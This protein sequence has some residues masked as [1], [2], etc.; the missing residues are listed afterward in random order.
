MAFGAPVGESDEN[1]EGTAGWEGREGRG[2]APGSAPE[3]DAEPRPRRASDD[4]GRGGR[5]V[6]QVDGSEG[7]RTREPAHCAARC[8][9]HVR[10]TPETHAGER[11]GGGSSRL[12]AAGP[13]VFGGPLQRAPCA[14][15]LGPGVRRG[16]GPGRRR[17]GPARASLCVQR[18][19]PGV[20]PSPS[21]APGAPPPLTSMCPN[22]CTKG[23]TSSSFSVAR[24]RISLIS[25]G[26]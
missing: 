24:R 13:G 5:Q 1:P 17:A 22:V 4:P 10:V 2:R 12:D 25:E 20:A 14:R 11:A 6:W 3:P 15:H 26:L 18:F 19:L 7:S 23:M 21:L 16:P 8:G 9:K